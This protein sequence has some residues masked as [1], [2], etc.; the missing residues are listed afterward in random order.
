MDIIYLYSSTDT[1]QSFV[2]AVRDFCTEAIPYDDRG[3]TYD[4]K[5]ESGY[6]NFNTL[7]TCNFIF[8]YTL[9]K[10][11]NICIIESDMVLMDKIDSIFSLKSPAVLTYYI[12]ENRLKYNDKIT[13]TPAD[14]ISKCKEMGRIN[15]GVMLIQPSMRLFEKYKEKIRDV[16]ANTCKYP[17]ETLF[18][19]VNNSYYNLPVQYNLSH[20]HA[21]PFILK[22]YGLRPS[23]ILVF[24]FNETKYK[25]ID[26]IKNPIGES[27]EDW[28][29][30]I[31]KDPKYQIRKL[32]ILHYRDST[33]SRY[34]PQI[35]EIME[36]VKRK[37]ADKPADKLA[38]KLAIEAIAM[39]KPIADKPITDK[40][41]TDKPITDK[42]IAD[43]PAEKPAEA[44][45]PIDEKTQKWIDRINTLVGRISKIQS[46]NELK[47]FDTKYIQP[48]LEINAKSKLVIIIQDKIKVLTEAYDAKMKSF[49]EFDS[50]ENAYPRNPD[51]T[52]KVSPVDPVIQKILDMKLRVNDDAE[53]LKKNEEVLKSVFP[54]K[55]PTPKEPTS[56]EP[57]PKE[58]TPKEPT[59]KEP[60]P[61]EPTP[62]EPT[63]KEPTPK[64]PTPKE[65]TPKEP[66]TLSIPLNKKCP[67]GFIRN[68]KT[69][70]CKKKKTQKKA[71]PK[72]PIPKEPTP[73]EPTP[74]EPTPKEPTPKE[75][76][77]K[78]PTPKTQKKCPKG[79]RR[80]K[81]TGNCEPK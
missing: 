7:R 34:E 14:V 40:P 64:E 9:E 16:V 4:V 45:I 55:E 11:D 8:A 12:G 25:H 50:Y 80:N 69:G 42:P 1:P 61:K 46:E 53:L 39:D 27:G 28:M 38:D 13:N 79:F 48:I 73:K 36:N 67:N 56:K 20:Y 74:K 43:T 2:D 3:I 37:L 52:I 5:F 59:P 77:P 24:H 19:Y 30:I 75:P 51:G 78:E 10:Y 49:E 58:P 81:K 66:T 62:K 21:K 35:R 23:E 15:G 41:I 32:P 71:S 17:N 72:E 60:T 65:P 22:K 63:P 26:I 68:K 70:K 57:T 31:Q 33:Y 44:T 47:K 54:E 18:E 6:S 76:T 29:E